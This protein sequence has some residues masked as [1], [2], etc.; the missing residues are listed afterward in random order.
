MGFFN[1]VIQI[2]R[3]TKNAE[4]KMSKTGSAI[5][6]FTIG[7][8][9]LNKTES[10]EFTTRSNFFDV[11]MFGKY[12][13][14]CMQSLTKGR[15]VAIKGRLKQERWEKDGQ[16][17]SKIVIYADDLQIL[18]EPKAH[19]PTEEPQNANLVPQMTEEEILQNPIF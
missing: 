7:V 4:M 18:R 11:V 9:E 3:L 2:G 13:Q 15:E 1:S 8:S 10:G 5:V 12:P 6:N 17:Y 19:E 14:A 16:H